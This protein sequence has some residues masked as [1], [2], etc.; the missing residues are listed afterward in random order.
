MAATFVWKKRKFSMLSFFYSFIRAR[1]LAISGTSRATS[2]KRVTVKR[3]TSCSASNKWQ[4]KWH[5]GILL[6]FALKKK[7]IFATMTG[8]QLIIFSSTACP[9]N[10]RP[11]GGLWKWWYTSNFWQGRLSRG[12]NQLLPDHHRPSHSHRL[13]VWRKSVCSGNLPIYIQT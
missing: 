1:F 5:F 13:P 8:V 10:N 3:R 12:G 7:C 4:S 11:L 2:L 6:D 9:S